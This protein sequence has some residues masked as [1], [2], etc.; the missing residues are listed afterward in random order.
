[1]VPLVQR[2]INSSI[3]ASTGYTPTQLI[4]G[5]FIDLNKGFLLEN[6]Q[7]GQQSRTYTE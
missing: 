3:H 6:I 1:M 4:F 2:I 5:N 7:S